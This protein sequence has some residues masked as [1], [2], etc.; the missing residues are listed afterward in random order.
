MRIGVG[1]EAALA[2]VAGPWPRGPAITDLPMLG[3]SRV[4]HSDRGVWI[5]ADATAGRLAVLVTAVL[6]SAGI[7]LCCLVALAVPSGAWA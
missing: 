3:G 7:I 6:T 1:H 2:W 4:R 5:I